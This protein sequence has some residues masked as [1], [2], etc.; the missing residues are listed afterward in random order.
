MITQIAK[1]IISTPFSQD[2]HIVVLISRKTLVKQVTLSKSAIPCLDIST[3]KT[4]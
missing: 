4:R 3:T 2:K 1:T